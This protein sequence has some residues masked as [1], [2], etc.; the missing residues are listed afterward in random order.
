MAHELHVVGDDGF[1]QRRPP[2][3][4]PQVAV[5]AVYDARD[6]L[7]SR[8]ATAGWC[9]EEALGRRL[10]GGDSAL[11]RTDEQPREARASVD[12][13][14]LHAA[15]CAGPEQSAERREQIGCVC[16]TFTRSLLL[17]RNRR[18]DMRQAGQ[19]IAHPQDLLGAMPNGTT[20]ATPHEAERR[21]EIECVQP[22]VL[23]LPHL[24]DG[25][26]RHND[27]GL[28]LLLQRGLD[29]SLRV[30]AAGSGLAAA[31]HATE[32]DKYLA[33]GR[34]G[35]LEP[36]AHD[37]NDRDIGRGTRRREH[38]AEVDVRVRGTRS[39]ARTCVTAAR[40]PT[41]VPLRRH[42]EGRRRLAVRR[43]R[44]L[45]Q[46]RQHRVARRRRGYTD[47]RRGRGHVC[48]RCANLLGRGVRGHDRGAAGVVGATRSGGGGVVVM[49]NAVVRGM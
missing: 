46:W 9:E 36:D 3:C 17:F 11:T 49:P 1:V 20:P 23:H 12:H 34:Q 32:V 14:V 4:V 31:R 43:R 47:R 42:H 41:E 5:A 2:E 44:L 37:S 48:S 22:Y 26:V 29:R 6:V 33:E 27:A 10:V 16:E 38:D 21:R 19:H 24:R 30:L 35:G 39:S 13:D 25:C 40:I 28:V 15:P 45:L 18:C 8:D 7:H